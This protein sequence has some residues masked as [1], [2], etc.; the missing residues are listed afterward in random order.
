M[1][2][3]IAIANQ[4]GGVAKTTTA[5]NL[6]AS[7]A[8][9]GERVLLV[10]L[11]PQGNATSGL[12]VSKGKLTHCVYDVLINEVAL[13]RVILKTDVK[14]LRLVP[15]RIELAGAEIELVSLMSRESRLRAA[16]LKA[17]KEYDFILIDCPPSLGL[18][19]LNALTA[20]D[21]VLIPVQC[22]YYALEGLSL[23]MNTL[24]RVTKHLNPHLTVLGALLTMFD[25]RTNLA[26][27]VVEE[28]KRFFGNKVF[29]TIVP[30]NVRLGEAPS[31][32]KPIV[33]YDS[34]SRGAEVYRDLAKEVLERV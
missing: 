20:A 4:K 19:T 23:L 34:R 25:G 22:E 2:K 14:N 12:G 30:R 32:G 17:R 9:V 11:D 24:N 31:H 29:Q 28:V 13:E 33:T 3:V 1:A 6:G 10:D 21:Y 26:I 8:E 5:I 7:L 18:L 15:A 16:L 27:Q